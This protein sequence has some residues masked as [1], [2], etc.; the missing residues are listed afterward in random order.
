MAVAEALDAAVDAADVA[1]LNPTRLEQMLNPQG[2]T[3]GAESD[4]Q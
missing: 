1:G 4:E 3:A 2:L